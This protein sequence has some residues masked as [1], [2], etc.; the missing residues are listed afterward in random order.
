MSPI[1]NNRCLP[2]SPTCLE[3]VPSDIPLQ[4][5]HL[6]RPIP[7]RHSDM[8]HSTRVAKKGHGDVVAVCIDPCAASQPRYRY[9]CHRAGFRVPEGFP[10]QQYVNI[11]R[12]HLGPWDPTCGILD[13]G[14]LAGSTKLLAFVLFSTPLWSGCSDVT[15]GKCTLDS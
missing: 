12:H 2:S 11:K 5:T 7:Q 4:R 6:T 1:K 8:P 10:S 3:Y 14:S 9:R 15:W 13:L